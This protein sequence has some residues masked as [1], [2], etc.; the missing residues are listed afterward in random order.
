M[1]ISI[2]GLALAVLFAKKAGLASRL[3]AR[4]S[5]VV[6]GRYD[7]RIGFGPM[8]KQKYKQKTLPS[9][10]QVA[11]HPAHAVAS[12]EGHLLMDTSPSW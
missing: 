6:F 12:W 1:A 10:V 2:S 4:L 3:V 11:E 8:H 9:S 5:L 7:W